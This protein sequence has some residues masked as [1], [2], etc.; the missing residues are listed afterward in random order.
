M[1]PLAPAP[2]ELDV[3]R[4]KA[5]FPAL[6]EP[7]HGL[8]L[9]F[10]D[11]AASA[12]KPVAVLDTMDALYRTTYANVHRGIYAFSE[13]STA[14]YEASRARVAA[15][16]HARSPR[17]V[18]FTRNATEALNLVA[19][20]YGHSMLRPGDQI[21]ITE[22]EHH[23]NFL[24]WMVLAKER[25]LELRFIPLAADGTLDLSRLDE[26]ITPRTR[27]VSFA[28][29]SNVLGTITDPRPIVARARA[30]GAV[31]VL[32]GCQSV[33]H[34]PVDVQVLDIDFLAFS[35]HKMLGPT[36]IGVL[37]GREELL[38]VMPPFLTGGEMMESVTFEEVVWAQPPQRF[39]AGTPAF[40]EAVGLGAAIDYLD[41]LGMSAV[42][43][44][45]QALTAYALERL[46]GVAGLHIVG[47]RDPSA[48]AGV[49]AFTLDGVHPHD[50][51]SLLDARGIAIRAGKHCAHPLHLRLG[52]EDGTARASFS[53]YNDLAD[54]DALVDGIQAA[55]RLF[56]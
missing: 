6:R 32:D 22:L 16:I 50:L 8:P 23:A 43:A 37:W 7:V 33:P 24:P 51:A 9:V 48:R 35:G 28:H 44:H 30:V 49:I 39:E 31:V 19:F 5:D 27:L 26:L 54:V 20:S 42:H 10:L 1:P 47:P 18:I 3:A 13:E 14:R 25:G 52:L 12:Q 34:L 2:A 53:V 17:E 46:G 36:G 45:E 56:T 38:E 21:V 11:S 41:A 40:V 55:Q 29:V 4:V 15:F